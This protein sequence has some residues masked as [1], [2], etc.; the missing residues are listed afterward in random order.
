MVGWVGGGGGNV[1][2]VCSCTVVSWLM[3]WLMKNAVSIVVRVGLPERRVQ[4]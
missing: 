4:V 2:T 3:N 1:G